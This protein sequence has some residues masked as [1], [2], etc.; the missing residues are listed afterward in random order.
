MEENKNLF[1]RAAMTYGLFM[2]IYWVIKYLFFIFSVTLSSHTLSLVYTALTVIVPIFAFYMTKKYKND[3]GGIISFFHAWRFGMMLYFFAAVIVSLAHFV[4][5]Q[6]IAPAD[7]VM[8]AVGQFANVLKD[9]QVD[10]ELVE[11]LGN[12][13]MSP[14]HMAIQG[15]FNNVFYGII[16]SI[17]VAAII[18]KKTQK[19][20]N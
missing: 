11:S 15:I 17:P 13:N 8:D 7:F 6:F 9:Q 5:F 16:F 18:C 4:F 10:T 19:P 20:A 2:G 12:I 3:I 14:I 1:L